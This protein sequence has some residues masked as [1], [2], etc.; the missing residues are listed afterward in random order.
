LKVIPSQCQ[1]VRQVPTSDLQEPIVRIKEL[2]A[3]ELMREE[4]R[5]Y[6]KARRDEMARLYLVQAEGIV[7]GEAGG[8]AE[9]RAEVAGAGVLRYIGGTRPRCRG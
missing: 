7:E 8:R 9:G 6:E 1:V 5:A 4:R 2:S 3:D